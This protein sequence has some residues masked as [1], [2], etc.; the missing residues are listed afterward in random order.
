MLTQVMSCRV[1][2]AC[3]IQSRIPGHRDSRIEVL[4]PWVLLDIHTDSEIFRIRKINLFT[5]WPRLDHEQ[6]GQFADFDFKS[7]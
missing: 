1:F 2:P 5:V 3:S 7:T 6:I 4:S